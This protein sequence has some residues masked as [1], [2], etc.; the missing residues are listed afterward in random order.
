[1]AGMSSRRARS[2]GTV[3]GTTASRKYRSSRN[4]PACDLA[5][6]VAVGRG[7]DAHVGLRA[8]CCRRRGGTPAS[9]ARGG[10]SAA[11]RAAAR[12]SRRGTPCRR[13]RA[14]RRPDAS[15]TAP[16]NAPRSWPKSSLSMSESRDR[17]AVDDDER[18]ARAR[19]APSRSRA[20]ARPCRCRSRLRGARSRRSA[21]CARGRRRW[22]ASRGSAPMAR[23]EVVLSLG[24]TSSVAAVGLN[25]ISTSPTLST[26]PG[27]SI[28]SRMRVPSTSC[29]WWTRDRGRARRRARG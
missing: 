17:A 12:R 1:M 8:S 22:C 27:W 19:A 18:L 26:L 21:R 23:A 6:E 4:F 25:W 29:R 10:A 11:R 7:D 15:A 2:G 3:T 20:R 16:V 28:A 24:S 13:R 9:R 14:R 5:L